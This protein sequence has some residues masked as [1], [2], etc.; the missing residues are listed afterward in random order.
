MGILLVS[1][2]EV[3]KY[4]V[5]ACSPSSALFLVQEAPTISLLM[6]QKVEDEEALF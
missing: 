2:S 5:S 1:F 6:G 3:V 4:Q